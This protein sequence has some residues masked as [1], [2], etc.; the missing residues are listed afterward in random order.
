[1]QEDNVSSPVSSP[2]ST[3]SDTEELGTPVTPDT[4]TLG[5][6]SAT[7]TPVIRHTSIVRTAQRQS[8]AYDRATNGRIP[9]V[10]NQYQD[11]DNDRSHPVAQQAAQLDPNLEDLN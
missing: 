6:S 9:T 8:L 4:S 5:S 1:M 10:D 2:S 7:E 11:D 3:S